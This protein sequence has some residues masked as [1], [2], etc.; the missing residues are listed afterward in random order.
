MQLRLTAAATGPNLVRQGTVPLDALIPLAGDRDDS[1][2]RQLAGATEKNAEYSEM[3]ATLANLKVTPATQWTCLSCG[4]E[5]SMAELK[6]TR[7]RQ[8]APG[9]VH[10]LD[11]DRDQVERLE[12]RPLRYDE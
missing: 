2:R 5:N 1:V 4:Q 6:C 3:R 10:N 9:V 7:C 12:R 8:D 11:V